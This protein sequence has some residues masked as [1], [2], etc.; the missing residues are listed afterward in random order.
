M[1]LAC[2]YCSCCLRRAVGKDFWYLEELFDSLVTT[3]KVPVLL[4][5]SKVPHFPV[6]KMWATVLFLFNNQSFVSKDKI[7]KYAENF[8]GRRNHKIHLIGIFFSGTKSHPIFY[9][10][11]SLFFFFFF[12]LQTIIITV[13]IKLGPTTKNLL[14]Q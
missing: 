4:Q 9:Y 12:F 2:S 7:N 6:S 13:M 11:S 14:K 1:W 3:L 8:N 5:F 10:L